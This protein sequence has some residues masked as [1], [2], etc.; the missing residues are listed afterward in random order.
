MLLRAAQ[1]LVRTHSVPFM[2]VWHK[3]SLREMALLVPFK[4]ISLMSS[5]DHLREPELTAG[6]SESS[7]KY[8]LSVWL[9]CGV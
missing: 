7:W 1:R 2:V 8:D 9:L 4:E 3:I 6:G 5:S